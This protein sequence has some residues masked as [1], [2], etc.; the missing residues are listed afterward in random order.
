MRFIKNIIK[1]YKREPVAKFLSISGLAVIA[2]GSVFVAVGN[3][4]M[5]DAQN[6]RSA[7][8]EEFKSSQEYV[9]YVDEETTTL[10]FKL[11][12]DE[13][14]KE[15]YNEE[16]EKL[17]DEKVVEKVLK[18]SNDYKSQVSY[19]KTQDAVVDSKDKVSGGASFAILGAVFGSM[20]L[21]IAAAECP[22]KE[23]EE[24]ENF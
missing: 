6:L 1:T 22:R 16:I 21:T 17:N 9:D 11:E 12:K 5:K 7:E 2:I 18:N 8:L 10:N 3:A 19:E 14:T 24:Y 23:D 15:Q 20:G 4:E 13:I